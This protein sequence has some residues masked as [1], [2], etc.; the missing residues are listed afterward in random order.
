M[1]LDL[2]FTDYLDAYL[3]AKAAL[4]QAHKGSRQYEL[5]YVELGHCGA[6]LNEYIEKLRRRK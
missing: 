2:Q 5:A 6:I 4:A 3:Q 1:S